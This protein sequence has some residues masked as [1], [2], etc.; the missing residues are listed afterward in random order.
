MGAASAFQAFL[1]AG[2]VAGSAGEGA[3][4]LDAVAFLFALR[5]F[6]TVVKPKSLEDRLQLA[7][8]SARGGTTTEDD[9]ELDADVV[10]DETFCDS[11]A[12][13]AKRFEPLNVNAV[14]L[15]DR[16]ISEL[17]LVSCVLLVDGWGFF[18]LDFL[19]FMVRFATASFTVVDATGVELVDASATLAVDGS[20][21]FDVSAAA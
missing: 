2:A 3:V 12:R 1:S 6:T 5:L 17:V 7:A 21:E 10:D 11:R 15:L 14:V 20:K 4:D 19:R 16:S 18:L 13:G 8:L 9:D